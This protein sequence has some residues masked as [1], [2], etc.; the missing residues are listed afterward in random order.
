MVGQC[1]GPSYLRL[2]GGRLFIPFMLCKVVIILLLGQSCRAG[3]RHPQVALGGM[4]ACVI[5][6]VK[7]PVPYQESRAL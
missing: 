5:I 3:C 6:R 2:P 7:N 1:R 4:S